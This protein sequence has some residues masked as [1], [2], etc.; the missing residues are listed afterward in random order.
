M[1]VD[2]C[3][4]VRIWTVGT[5]CYTASCGSKLRR[6]TAAHDADYGP[7]LSIRSCDRIFD[8]PAGGVWAATTSALPLTSNGWRKRIP[9]ETAKGLD[10]KGPKRDSA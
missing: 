8:R 9:C 3:S 7:T 4:P 5:R 6:N 1:T 2:C 10:R